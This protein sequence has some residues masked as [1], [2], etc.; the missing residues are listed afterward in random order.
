MPRKIRDLARLLEKAGFRRK[1]GKGSHRKYIH[2]DGRQ[3]VMSGKDGDD[4]KP[5]QEKQVM[6]QL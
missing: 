4:A 2:P 5:Y 3:L 6:K 1:S